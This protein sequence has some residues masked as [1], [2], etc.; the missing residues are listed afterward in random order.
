V[1]EQPKQET[2]E[3][4]RAEWNADRAYL[5]SVEPDYAMPAWSRAPA[6]RRLPYLLDPDKCRADRE[7]AQR[8]ESYEAVND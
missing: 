5:R 3:R 6:W 2:T 7:A 4:A 8:G 1:T